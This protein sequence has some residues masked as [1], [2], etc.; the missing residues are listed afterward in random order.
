[1]DLLQTTPSLVKRA[2]GEI[3]CFPRQLR[4]DCVFSDNVRYSLGADGMS[5]AV[6]HPTTP[7]VCTPC[8]GRGTR[9]SHRHGNAL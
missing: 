3:Y 4:S 5:N 9:R 1:M 6:F 8:A 7:T 2:A